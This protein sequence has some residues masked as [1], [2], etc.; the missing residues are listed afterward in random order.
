MIE[1]LRYLRERIQKDTFKKG[2]LLIPI[3]Y[4]R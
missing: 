1:K 4:L 2:S 3:Y